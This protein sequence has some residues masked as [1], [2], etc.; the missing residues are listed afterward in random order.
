MDASQLFYLDSS[1][2][3]Y[4]LKQ[5]E[6]AKNSNMRKRRIDKDEMIAINARLDI[7]TPSSSSSGVVTSVLEAVVLVSLYEIMPPPPFE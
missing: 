7:K 2:F 4:I 5:N 3:L 1:R 6:N